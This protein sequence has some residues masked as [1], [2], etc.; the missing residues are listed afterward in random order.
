MADIDRILQALKTEY[1]EVRIS[2]ETIRLSY[3]LLQDFDWRLIVTLV[4]KGLWEIVNIE[5][6]NTSDKN[7]AYAAD[8]GSTTV[9]MQRI[10]LNTGNIL[11]EESGVNH[12]VRFGADIPG[13]EIGVP[14]NGLVYCFPSR[15]LQIS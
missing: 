5:R 4:Q 3:K 14:F 6:G 10:D 9:V 15:N 2:I 12:Q 1:G 8:L 7:F 11:C 13:R